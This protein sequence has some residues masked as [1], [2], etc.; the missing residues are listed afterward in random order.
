VKASRLF[1]L[2]MVG[3]MLLA[4]GC[5]APYK[6]HPP[7]YEQAPQI[8]KIGL[9]PLIYAAEGKDQRLFGLTFSS[10]FPDSLVKV[11]L[12]PGVS[13]EK[14]DAVLAVLAAKG[15]TAADSIVVPGFEAVRFPAYHYPSAEIVQA[16]AGSYD[17]LIVPTLMAYHEVSAGAQMGQMCLTAC[18]TGGLVVASEENSVRLDFVLVG[19]NSQQQLWTYKYASA[20]EMGVQR[21]A[22]SKKSAKSFAKFFPFSPTFKGNK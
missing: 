18:L 11:P 21:E 16:L 6:L 4:V 19:I 14:P 2:I 8:K 17:G 12:Q 9:Y 10:M 7:F 13:I 15:I 3:V 1:C 5:A 20:G 22:Y